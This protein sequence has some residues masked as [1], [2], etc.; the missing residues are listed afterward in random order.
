MNWVDGVVIIVLILFALEAIGRSFVAE[1]LDF[2]S[3]LLAG[4]LSFSYYN[5]IAKYLE[6]KFPIPHGLSL[7]I[8]F[9]LI[10]F[11]SE[12]LFYLIVRF[13]T[14]K[15]TKFRFPGSEILSVIPGLL[16]GLIFIALTLVMID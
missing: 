8:G 14:P 3:F 2:I 5:I 4:L 9:I 13:L 10:W 12:T 7:I 11:L 6:S 15:I 1:T 16:R